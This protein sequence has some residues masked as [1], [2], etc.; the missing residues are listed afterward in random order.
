[1]QAKAAPLTSRQAEVRF[2][3]RD[4]SGRRCADTV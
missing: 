4:A 2:A 1:M 3:M